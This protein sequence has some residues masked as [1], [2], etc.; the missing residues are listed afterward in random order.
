VHA[1]RIL[2]ILSLGLV[3]ASLAQQSLPA[4]FR[5]NGKE[6]TAVFE[7]QRAVLQSSSAVILDGRRDIGYAVVVS[8]DGHLLAKA[9]EVAKAKKLAVTVDATQYKDVQR[10]AEDPVWDV[11]LL[12]IPAAGLVPVRFSEAGEPPQGT[13][14]VSNGATTRTHRRALAG[15]ISAKPREIPA[16]DG[17]AIGISFKDE[18]SLKISDLA[19]SGGAKAAG[20]KVGDVI[21][22]IDDKKVANMKDLS[23]SLKDRKAGTHVRVTYSRDG[24]ETTV[25]VLLGSKAELFANGEMMD[26]ND[27]MSGDVSK[28]R[29][30]FPRIIQHDTLSSGRVTGGPLLN[31]DGECVGMNIARANR[32]ENFAIPAAELRKLLDALLKQSAATPAPKAD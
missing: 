16:A 22:A 5:L 26:R 15:I 18:K 30:G 11:V 31:L 20:L 28:R 3:S 32:C 21:V 6:V 25:E 19:E 17:V 9:S 14:V 23:D 1:N 8:P 4:D 7:P 27:M 10:L 2:C 24:S 12:K 13:W 29:S